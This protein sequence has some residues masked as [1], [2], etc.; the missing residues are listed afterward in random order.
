MC[1]NLYRV[2][3]RL[4]NRTTR[5]YQQGLERTYYQRLPT[6]VWFAMVIL[7]KLRKNRV[8]NSHFVNLE[9]NKSHIQDKLEKNPNS[10]AVTS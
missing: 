7:E 2:P 8:N 5:P 9:T 3:G 10:L 4:F 6:A 1:A